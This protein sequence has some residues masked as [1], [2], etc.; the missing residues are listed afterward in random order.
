MAPIVPAPLAGRRPVAGVEWGMLAS[1]ELVYNA[2]P[3][4]FVNG[5]SLAGRTNRAGATA[6]SSPFDPHFQRDRPDTSPDGQPA[7]RP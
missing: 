5:V 7:S 3:K 2:A 6:A 4:A 1:P